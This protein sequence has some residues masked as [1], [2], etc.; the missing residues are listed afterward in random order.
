M[1][2]FI[3]HK[4]QEFKCEEFLQFV[5]QSDFEETI[6]KEHDS[7]LRKPAS[8]SLQEAAK[9][10]NSHLNRLG[11]LNCFDHSRVILPVETKHRDYINGSYVDGYNQARKF[12]CM[13]APMHHTNY[14]LWRTVWMNNSRIIV[15][16]CEKTVFDRKMDHAYWCYGEGILNCEKFKIKTKKVEVRQNYIETTLEVTDGTGASRKVLHLAFTTWP[17]KDL[18]ATV[19]DF[20]DFVLAVKRNNEEIKTRLTQEGC[21]VPNPPIIVHSE[22][23]ANRSGAFCAIEIAMSQYNETGIIS[24]ASIVTRIREQRYDAVS[25]FIHYLFCYG[26]LAKYASFFQPSEENMVK[27]NGSSLRSLFKNVTNPNFFSSRNVKS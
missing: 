3:S 12:I 22:I 7:I 23:G 14:D 27:Q 2:S 1:F 20:L 26:V 15:M 17:D 8:G 21:Q 19:E 5:E 10:E 18:P 11:L 9:F 24:L 25:R 6:R 4:S 13:Q 16:L